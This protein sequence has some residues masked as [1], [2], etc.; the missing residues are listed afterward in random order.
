L[1]RSDPPHG[2]RW[3]L[4]RS[5]LGDYMKRWIFRT[6]WGTLRIHCILKSD[7]GRDFHDHPFS[8]VSVI[9]RGGYIEHRPECRCWIFRWGTILQW[10]CRRFTAPALVVRKAT[11][12]H[13]LELDRPAWTFVI[14][15]RY[16]RRWGFLTRAGWVD[17]KDYDR[18]YYQS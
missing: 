6:P 13:R 9:F 12:M 10:P 8:F 11:D 1:K 14:T 5:D 16:F 17:F 7:E 4:Y 18:S 3:A 15:T 2:Q